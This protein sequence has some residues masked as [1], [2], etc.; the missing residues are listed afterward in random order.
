MISI[1]NKSLKLQKNGLNIIDLSPSSANVCA[2][3]CEFLYCI[4][5]A[6]WVCTDS[7]HAVV[8]S[9]IF[10]KDFQCIER[11]TSNST[12]IDGMYSRMETLKNKLKLNSGWIKCDEVL[13]ADI[14]HI[15]YSH[16][17]QRIEEERNLAYDFLK[18]SLM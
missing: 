14:V 10:N 6:Q 3:P 16:I 7:F 12:E 15:D 5:N 1:M 17:E 4:A 9:A 11:N 18:N 13:P 8:F 2:G